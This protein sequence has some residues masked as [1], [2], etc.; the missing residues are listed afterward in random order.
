MPGPA[1]IPDRGPE[2]TIIRALAERSGTSTSWNRSGMR[3]DLAPLAAAVLV[4]VAIHVCYLI[5]ASQG[6][7]EWCVPYWD[8]CTTISRAGRQLP[9]VFVYRGLMTPAAAFMA[10]Y[11]LLCR[12]WLTLVGDEA[13]RLNTVVAVAGVIAAI[14]LVLFSSILGNAH[15]LLKLPRRVLVDGFFAGTFCA[16][17][18]L[19][20]R[21]GMLRR[22]VSATSLSRIVGFKVAVVLLQ[23]LLA[24]ALLLL[25]PF[26]D[27]SGWLDDAA[28][29]NWVVLMSSFFV[30]SFLAWRKT[31]FE[32]R[33]LLPGSAH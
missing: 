5:S 6:L 32:G 4:L 13:H 12:E 31:R 8:G 24:A 29:W 9:A 22:S 26:M 10:V 3:F 30:A 17:I 28:E 33:L 1:R 7:V 14:C 15:P 20:A 2:T 25:P 19:L 21:L 16:E 27:D 18:A 23:A 11:W